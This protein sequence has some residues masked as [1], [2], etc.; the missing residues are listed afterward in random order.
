MALK[1]P[2]FM[3]FDLDDTILEYERP[4]AAS[5]DVVADDALAEDPGLDRDA[6]Y[7]RLMF[8]RKAFWK[9]PGTVVKGRLN[10]VWARQMVI[11]ASY[12]DLG[13]EPSSQVSAMAEHYEQARENTIRP[14]PKALETIKRI[15][16]GKSRLGMVTNGAG[17]IQRAKIQRFDLERYFQIIV[18]EGEFG[19][20][21]INVAPPLP[22]IPRRVYSRHS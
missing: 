10:L 11:A 6:L 1:L 3:L 2:P 16:A 22:P 20:L 8:H 9:N 5:W 17:A 13:L 19:R 15:A 4:A 12:R 18:V 14:F 7:A 21:T